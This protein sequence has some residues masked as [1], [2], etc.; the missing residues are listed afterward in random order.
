MQNGVL[1]LGVNFRTFF[2]KLKIKQE[3]ESMI[4]ES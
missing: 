1:R 3:R 2:S 4:G